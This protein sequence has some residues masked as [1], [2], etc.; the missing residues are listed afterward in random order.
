MPYLVKNSGWVNVC[1]YESASVATRFI[2]MQI[3]F[4]GGGWIF[5]LK[6]LFK[7]FEVCIAYTL[8]SMKVTLDWYM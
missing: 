5:F 2:H 4:F 6:K 7:N 8:A 1:T 3:V